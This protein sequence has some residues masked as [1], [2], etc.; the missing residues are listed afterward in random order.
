MSDE[1]TDD[2]QGGF[3]VHQLKWRS[4]LLS[5]LIS[6][7]DKRYEGDRKVNRAKPRESRRIGIPSVRS[8]PTNAVKWALDTS[9]QT[10]SS[11][12][13]ISDEE[14]S[15]GDYGADD[16]SGSGGAMSPQLHTTCAADGGCTPGESQCETTDSGSGDTPNSLPG[17]TAEPTMLFETQYVSS[18]LSED[19][20]DQEL[21]SLIR[22]ATMKIC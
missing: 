5:I 17:F 12:G 20:S 4:K 14:A 21:N 16:G 19:E 8:P 15:N 2:E 6:R 13:D 11:A 22:A 9:D 7:A 18:E 10:M 1:E 3:A